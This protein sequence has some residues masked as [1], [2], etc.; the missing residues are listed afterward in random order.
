MLANPSSQLPQKQKLELLESHMLGMPQVECPVVHHFG[1]GIYIREVHLK[2]GI[3]AI[4]HHQKKEHLNIVL[5]GAVAMAA[6]DG[7]LKVV[8][9]PTIFTGRP[10]R[11]L[12]YVLSD[13]IW[14]N[15][16][17][18]SETDIDK[19]ES[20][21]LDKSPT[22]QKF[23]EEYRELRKALHTKDRDSYASLVA[24]SEITEA[25]IRSQCDNEEDIVEMPADFSSVVSIRDSY[26]QGKGVFLT[27]PAARHEVIG[28][29][30]INGQR[31]VLG[32][33]TNHSPTPNAEFLQIENGDIYLVATRPILGCVGG[34]QGEEVTVDYSHTF[35]LIKERK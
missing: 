33:Y 12:G 2:A 17:A 32:R 18:T 9:G 15:V 29:A 6:D 35:K 28:P 26:I 21:Y 5:K 13:C 7:G 24:A 22:W 25:E 27:A 19:L 23:D 20:T 14:Q 11:K 30:R 3:F 34:D 31:T 8:S 10:G 1:P 4:G 16:Y